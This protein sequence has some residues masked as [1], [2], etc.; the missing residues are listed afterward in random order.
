[1]SGA[2]PLDD[3]RR[4]AGLRRGDPGAV[5]DL[6]DEW[7]TRLWAICRGMAA[8]PDQARVLLADIHHSLP[9]AVIGWS[10][11]VPICCQLARH[12]WSRLHRHLQ[13]AEPDGITLSVPDRTRSPA[14]SEVAARLA[15]LPPELRVIYLLDVFFSCPAAIL[16]ALSGWDETQV[17]RAR[18]AV[19]F[20]L[21]SAG[22]TP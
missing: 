17:R 8:D 16:A 9:S 12:T 11:E 15:E 13:L 18:A 6:W 20:H 3:A 21:V 1:M 10:L 4:L 7:K 5:A 14:A 19:A 2:I 22:G